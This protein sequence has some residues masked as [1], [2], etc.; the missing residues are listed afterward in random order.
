MEYPRRSIAK[1][2][3]WRG[4]AVLITAMVTWIVTDSVQFVVLI[5]GMDAVVKLVAY[6]LHER[7][8][9]RVGY[10]MLKEP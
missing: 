5:G 1:A 9:N 7:V 6:Y 2:L 3:S 10:G 4:V 8:W